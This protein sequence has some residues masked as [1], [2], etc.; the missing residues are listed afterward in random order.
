MNQCMTE[1]DWAADRDRCRSAFRL[2]SCSLPD[3]PDA[4]TDTQTHTHR[5]EQPSSGPTTPCKTRDSRLESL[6]GDRPSGHHPARS[7][8]NSRRPDAAGIN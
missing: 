2:R 6:L 3:R 1:T 8:S 7:R 4:E 5:T